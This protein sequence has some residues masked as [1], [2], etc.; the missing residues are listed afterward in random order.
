MDVPEP[1]DTVGLAR[2]AAFGTFIQGPL[3]TVWY[4][5]LFFILNNIFIIFFST[6]FNFV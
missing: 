6:L 5:I 4:F 2:Y 3:L 1:I